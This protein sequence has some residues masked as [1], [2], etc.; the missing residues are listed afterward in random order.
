M[1]EEALVEILS[2]NIPES[3]GIADLG[4]SS[5]P[6]TLSVISQIMYMIHG[7]CCHMGRS[8]PEFRL[9]LN[10][11]Y[12]NDFNDIFVSLPAFYNKIKEEKGFDNKNKCRP[13]QVFLAR[14]P[15]PP[16]LESNASTALNKGKLYISK[17]SPK[18]VLDAYS[19]QFH[20]DFSSFLKSRSLEVVSGGR[21]VLTLMGRSTSDATT[22]DS[23]YHWE[24]LAQAL[25]SMVSEGLVKEEMVDS[26]NAP[27]YAPCAEELKMA[28]ENDGSF[29]VDRLEAFEIEWDGG[30]GIMNDPFER[31]VR[32]AKTIR[33]VVESMLESQFGKHIMDDLFRRY[34]WLVG[35]YLA[36]SKTKYVNLVVSLVKKDLRAQENKDY[37]ISDALRISSSCRG[38]QE[39]METIQILHMNKGAGD[40]SYAQNSTVQSKIISIAKPV[41]EEAIIGS[42]SINIPESMGI[43]DLGCSSGPNTLSVIS[44]I[45]DVVHAKCCSLGC[46][47]PEFSLFLNDLFNNDFNYI[48]AS[49]PRLEEIVSGGRMVLSLMGRSTSDPTTEDSCY[50]WE[51]LAQALM[52]MVSEGL[53]EEEKVDSFNAPYYAPCAEELKREIQNDGSFVLDHLEAFEIDWDGD[54]GHVYDTF[55]TQCRGR[56]VAKTIRAV[57]ESML[58]SHFGNDMNMDELFRRFEQ[59]VGDYLSKNKTKYMNF[60]V[61]LT[62]N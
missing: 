36:S 35:D 20:N 15:V 21:M 2:K 16:G 51:L 11:L 49:L 59:M 5:G 3:V 62:R 55:E 23:C 41:I 32:V 46:S 38:N 53:I 29:M 9:F 60:V 61:S 1:I 58:E 43:A 44:Q 6:N 31:G 27:Y 19:L 24:L 22:E 4:C 48:F 18:C 25:M 50:Q 42:L 13:I 12:S 17:S 8:S 57:V 33:A 30:C 37:C 7:Q 54:G 47:S 45:I 28:I 10:D 40:T 39:D 52:S 56:R 34:A 26:F 14:W